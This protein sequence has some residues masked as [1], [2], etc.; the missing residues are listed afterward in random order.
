MV[1]R[2]CWRLGLAATLCLGTASQA[3]MSV[4]LDTFVHSSLPKTLPEGTVVAKVEFEPRQRSPDVRDDLSRGM[5][6][7]VMQRVQ[8]DY[9]GEFLI[10]R[11]VSLSSCD[12]LPRDRSVG[13]VIGIP[14]RI[15]HGVLVVHP[16][17]VWHLAD[18]AR[19]SPEAF[20]KAALPPLPPE[21]EARFSRP[22]HDLRLWSLALIP[23]AA[24]GAWLAL[25]RRRKP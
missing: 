21:P 23:C 3:C 18:D 1:M 11:P 10:V 5:R 25:K 15:E 9:R 7:R 16:I 22:G 6:A 2:F 12:S 19:V 17:S 24:I 4:E 8:G 13:F 20:R 14:R